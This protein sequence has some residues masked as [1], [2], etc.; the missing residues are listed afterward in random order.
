M[1]QYLFAYSINDTLVNISNVTHENR[2]KYYCPSCGIE[3]SAVLGNKREPH[4]RHK[5][6][7]CSYESYLHKISKQLL[8]WRFDNESK[9]EISYYVTKYCPNTHCHLRDSRCDTIN[10]LR[11]INLKDEYNICEIEGS[12]KGFRADIKLSNSD[13][14]EAIPLFLEVAVT[15]KCSPEKIS[16]GVPIVE[17]S[18]TNERDVLQPLI[19]H[20]TSESLSKQR[21]TLF[22]PQAIE[23]KIK[24]HNFDRIMNPYKQISCFIIYKDRDGYIRGGIKKCIG[25]CNTLI[26]QHD[27]NS[28]FEI[29]FDDVDPTKR[30]KYP[31]RLFGVFLAIKEGINVQDCRIC[32]NYGSCSI[33][34][35]SID[36][37]TK[38]RFYLTRPIVELL[39]DKR[40]N[41]TYQANKCRQFTYNTQLM[42]RV[43]TYFKG[44]KYCV[45]KP[46]LSDSN[47]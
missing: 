4:F 12:Y 8:K 15:H 46:F 14:P 33:L 3:M 18:V 25:W 16:S 23:E 20:K 27:K 35:S 17:I 36:M 22:T 11:T 42:T 37:R 40:I 41:A 24:F 31:I 34:C 26:G 6:D 1:A 45:S 2:E 47:G 19:E 5:G 21:I 39:N 10:E 28:L 43:F 13:K 7:S 30:H 29:Q 44:L 9:F 32:R 38:K